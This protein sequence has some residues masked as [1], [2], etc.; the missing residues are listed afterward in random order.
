ME[1]LISGSGSLGKQPIRSSEDF[2]TRR[3]AWL[4]DHYSAL[5]PPTNALLVSIFLG[6]LGDGLVLFRNFIGERQDRFLDAGKLAL[7]RLCAP[8]IL[9]E[10][11]DNDSI[12]RAAL[13]LS[14]LR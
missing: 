14:H 10:G 7:N 12:H 4:S 9:R 11:A 13:A 3:A 8:E 2:R 1:G 6:Y 5:R